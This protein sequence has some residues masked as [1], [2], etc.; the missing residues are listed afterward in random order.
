[1]Q[2]MVGKINSLEILT[3]VPTASIDF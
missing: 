1:M 3:I 2:V